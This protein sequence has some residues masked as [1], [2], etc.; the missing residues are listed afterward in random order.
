PPE[1]PVEYTDG[2]ADPEFSDAN[3]DGTPD[4]PYYTDM[5]RARG[6]SGL[7]QGTVGAPGP[8]VR[9]GYTKYPDPRR[10][11]STGPA[12]APSLGNGTVLLRVTY[13]PTQGDPNSRFIVIESIGRVDGPRQVWRYVRAYKPLVLTDYARFIADRADTGTP[14][15]LGIN[16]FFDFNGD[17]V[18]QPWDVF[19]TRFDGQIY[20]NVPLVLVG[21]NVT[22]APGGE[23]IEINLRTPAAG[24]LDEQ[25]IRAPEIVL[26]PAMPPGLS[27]TRVTFDG[28][29][30]APVLDS[31]D[32]GFSTIAGAVTDE[33]GTADAAGIVR[34]FRRASAPGMYQEDADT[35][36]E[37]WVALTRESGAYVSYVDPYSGAVLAA[38]TG[39][40][41]FGEGIFVDNASEVQFQ[42]SL[43]DLESDWLRHLDFTSTTSRDSGWNALYTTYSPPGVEITLFPD[44]ATACGNNVANIHP[45]P[46]TVTPGTDDIWW[47][48]HQA[49]APGIRLER[50]DK[51]WRQPDGSLSGL[52]VVYMDYPTN[53][54]IAAEGNVRIKGI[55]PPLGTGGATRP[56]G[57]PRDFNLTVYSGATIYIDGPLM[58]PSTAGL[59][60]AGYTDSRI[61]LIARDSV[62]LNTTYM[63]P[64]L[65]SGVVPVVS[66]DPLNPDAG[67][68]WQLD[69]TGTVYAVFTIPPAQAGPA[70]LV[71]KHAGEDPGP[72]IMDLMVNGVP[73]AFGPG[74]PPPAAPLTIR[75]T[76]FAFVPAGLLPPGPQVSYA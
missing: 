49:G 32:P 23:T 22:G 63:V 33:R 58:R 72:A 75:P 11:R 55:L 26:E 62:C 46:A 43:Q 7:R 28:G 1:P 36:R 70:N 73:Y 68:H 15:K 35:G 10:L 52:Y 47:P 54:V 41:G 31:D 61:A 8:F 64:Q 16:P 53:G 37:R 30:P 12:D 60:G 48:N 39:Q 34:A 29:A 2:T 4:D 50:H 67:M 66:D 59:T 44:E 71:V 65:A 27:N 74:V 14:A 19:V 56:D 42:H 25:T 13:N 45:T 51:P 76:Q 9:R 38:N 40:W 6:W 18:Q 24:N 20:S 57:T 17:G 69:G 5:E 3:G 21:A